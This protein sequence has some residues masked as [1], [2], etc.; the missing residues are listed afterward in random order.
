M[1][2]Q[3]THECKKVG[4]L[5]KPGPTSAGRDRF[6][7][8]PTCPSVPRMTDPSAPH[9]SDCPE[10]PETVGRKVIPH[11][12]P[13]AIDPTNEW[14]FIT[15]CARDRGDAP[16]IQSTLGYE[17]LKSIEVYQSIG[18]WWVNVAVVMPD[19]LHLIVRVPSALSPVIASWKRWTAKNLGVRWQRDFFDHRIRQSESLREKSEYVLNNPVRAGLVEQSGDWPYRLVNSQRASIVK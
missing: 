3:P 12:P 6:P 9:P 14:F 19:H 8:G 2:R 7:S 17:L 16:L 10:C 15:I 18:K 11:E 1:H 4:G 5:G 13:W